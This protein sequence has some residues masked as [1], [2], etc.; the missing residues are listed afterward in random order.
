MSSAS[1]A[2]INF[3]DPNSEQ[4]FKEHSNNMCP[5]YKVPNNSDLVFNI[6]V[7]KNMLATGKYAFTFVSHWIF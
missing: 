5:A 3:N 2:S 6:N 7:V 4:I 1:F